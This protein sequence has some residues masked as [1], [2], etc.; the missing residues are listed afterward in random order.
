MS[1]HSLHSDDAGYSQTVM[2]RVMHNRQRVI[3]RT[4]RERQQRW[5]VNQRFARK[6]I[7]MLA[8]STGV[9]VVSLIAW[10]LYFANNNR[11][12]W[13]SRVGRELATWFSMPSIILGIHFELEIGNYFEEVYAWHNRTGAHNFRSGFRVLEI[14]NL[15]FDCKLFGGTKSK[16]IR[17]L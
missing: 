13:K 5:L 15:Y 10:A 14:H 9:G 6:G 3:I 11:S 4:W 12:T 16:M 1:L 7:T 2:D 8:C 17:G